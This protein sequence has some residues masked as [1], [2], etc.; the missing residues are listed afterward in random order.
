[1]TH[2][3]VGSGVPHWWEGDR[4][5]IGKEH[6]QSNK[7]STKSSISECSCAVSRTARTSRRPKDAVPPHV[8]SFRPEVPRWLTL[9]FLVACRPGQELIRI[10][11]QLIGFSE[12]IEKKQ[13]KW[14]GGKKEY[15]GFDPLFFSLNLAPL[16]PQST[17]TL[18]WSPFLKGE[19]GPF[20]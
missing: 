2:F 5:K 7:I 9:R 13:S 19:S 6:G 11:N 10:G 3:L 20:L 16:S 4:L 18:V 15:S 12:S 8:L 1:M 14:R 17:Y